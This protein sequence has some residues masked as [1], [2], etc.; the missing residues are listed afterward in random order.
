M[1]RD[2]SLESK[3]IQAPVPGDGL[4]AVAWADG[5]VS[6]I[7]RRAA[8]GEDGV[9]RSV[10]SVLEHEIVKVPSKLIGGAATHEPRLL[11]RH[12]QLVHVDSD[13]HGATSCYVERGAPHLALD[14]AVR[15]ALGLARPATAQTARNAKVRV[16][17]E[18]VTQAVH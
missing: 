11:T 15:V 8:V 5:R 12:L 13:T 16:S 14:S 10:L 9:L 3:A 2:K 18:P 4:L 7:H 1:S 6:L 17:I